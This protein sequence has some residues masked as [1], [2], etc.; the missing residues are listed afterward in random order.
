MDNHNANYIDL[1][2]HIPAVRLP[3]HIHARQEKTKEIKEL[4]YD[5]I[6]RSV[7]VNAF[8]CHSSSSIYGNYCSYIR[9]WLS[10]KALQV[11]A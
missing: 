9:V 1:H 4:S 3:G 11:I 10:F 8:V 6:V 5:D 2:N 7:S